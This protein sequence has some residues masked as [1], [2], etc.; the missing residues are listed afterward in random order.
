MNTIRIYNPVKQG[1]D[2]DPTGAFTRRW[3]PE[4]AGV[5]DAYLQRPWTWPEAGRLLGR[6]YP[7]PIVDPV[8]A[9]QAARAAVWGCRR[10]HRGDAETMRIVSRHASRKRPRRAKPKAVTAQL[11]LDL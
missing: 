11:S 6:A 4:L 3:L 8:E 2:Q 10:A 1:V 9:A 5:P 7:A